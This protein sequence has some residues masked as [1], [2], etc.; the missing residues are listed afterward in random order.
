MPPKIAQQVGGASQLTEALLD[1]VKAFGRRPRL[2]RSTSPTSTRER[3]LSKRID[4]ARQAGRWTGE[5]EYELAKLDD[6]PLV[7]ADVALIGSIRMP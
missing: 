5:F 7:A 6:A 4:K 1:E 3:N 2:L